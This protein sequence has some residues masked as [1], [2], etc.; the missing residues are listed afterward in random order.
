MTP[1]GKRDIEELAAL[2]EEVHRDTGT[3]TQPFADPSGL[4]SGAVLYV[5]SHC[6]FSRAAQLAVDNLHA[7][8]LTVKNVSDDAQAL[9][10]LRADSGS[11]TAPCL[12]IGGEAIPESPVIV[13]TLVERLAPVP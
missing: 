1:A 5:K 8:T 10:E 3:P 7:K 13:R 9:A 6:G 4:G 2:S 11:E 12:V